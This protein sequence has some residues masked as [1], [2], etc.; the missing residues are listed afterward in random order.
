MALTAISFGLFLS[1][2]IAVRAAN[3]RLFLTAS[4]LPLVYAFFGIR[5]LQLRFGGSWPVKWTAV[6]ALVV[7]QIT[8]GLY[9]WPLSPIRFGLLL[10]GPAYALVGIA[11]SL[12]ENASFSEVYFEPLVVMGII[13]LLAV[14]IG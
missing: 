1:T 13:L 11:A 14:F 3:M 8:I 9:Y 2:T 12:E 5:I 4:I 10:L 7:C 6:I